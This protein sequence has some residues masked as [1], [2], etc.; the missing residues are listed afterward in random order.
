MTTTFSETADIE[1]SSEAY[2]TRFAGQA[3]RYFLDVQT[4][5]T[6]DLL[7]GYEGAEVLDVGGGHC[8]LAEPLLARG[9]QVTITGSDDSC[10]TRAAARL[11]RQGRRAPWRVHQHYPRD[12]VTTLRTDLGRYLRGMPG[13]PD[14]STG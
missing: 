9:F 13:T 4:R 6:L 10:G 7:S 12:A 14:R 11:P 1:T 3:G 5:I 2:A 8:Q